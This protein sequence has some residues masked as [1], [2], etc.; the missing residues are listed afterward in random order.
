MSESEA[1]TTGSMANDGKLGLSRGSLDAFVNALGEG[2][3][4]DVLTFNVAANP[5]FRELRPALLHGRIMHC[6][7][8]HRLLLY[9]C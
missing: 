2:D 9:C 3:R 7:L 6:S 8:V 5:L 1:T 4:F